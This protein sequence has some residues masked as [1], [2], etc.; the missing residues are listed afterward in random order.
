MTDRNRNRDSDALLD[1]ILADA[2]A[3]APSPG[4][5][6]MARVMDDA[7]R[8]QA[9]VPAPP[10]PARRGGWLADLADVLGGWRGAGGL[11]TAAV[12]GLWIGLSDTAFSA[13]GLATAFGSGAVEALEVF[14]GP[15]EL[16]G[17]AAAEG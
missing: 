13:S 1:A 8:L 14:P 15:G 9:A 12:A 11:A 16:A 10:A 4:P 7:F 6:L 2:R 17:L 5:D 3:A